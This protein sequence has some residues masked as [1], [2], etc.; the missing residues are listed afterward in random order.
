MNIVG[1]YGAFDWDAN[2]GKLTD[3]FSVD[4]IESTS[5]SHD[6]GCTLFMDGKHI[7]SVSEERITRTKYDG[8]YPKNSIDLCL[9]KGGIHR[10]DIDLVYFVPTHHFIAFHQIKSGLAN[11]ILKQSFPKAE[12]RFTGHHLAHAASTVFTSDFNEGT[13]V[14]FDGGGS[15]IQDP[16]RDYVDHIENNSIGYFNKKKRIFRFYNMFEHQ[17]NNFGQLYQ[18]VASKI[19]QKKTGEEIKHWEGITASN[20]KIMGL[21]AYG[22]PGD[23]PKGYEVT[24]HSI[25]YI[26][27]AAFA[28]KSDYFHEKLCD[29]MSPEDAAYYLQRTFE[30]GMLDLLKSLRK[31]HLDKNTCFAG[32]VFLNVLGNTLIKESGIFEDIHI[33]PFT[34]DSGVHFGA[35]IWG[36]YEN[37]EDISLPDNLALLGRDF[38]NDEIVQ[39]LDMFDLSYRDYDIDIVA[40]L[41]KDNKIVA[42][43]QGRSEAGPRALGSRSIFMSPTRAEN[44]DIL[45]KRV[46][47]RDHWRPFAGTI[48]EDRVGEYFLEAYTSPYMLYSQHSTTD[49]LPAI[50]HEDKTCRIQTVNYD[51]NPRVHDLLTRLD[52]PVILNTS[53][54]DNGEPIIDS[55]YD[56]VRAFTHLDID[57]MVIGDFIVD[58]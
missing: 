52:P 54:N 46:K 51:Q 40:D 45:N 19:Y 48:L 35:A 43:F 9:D 1:I 5:W 24:E 13:F 26:N 42:W 34:D 3:Y 14:T 20:G 37:E 29:M 58:K 2:H 38:H 6:S 23:H 18:S 21:S 10:R 22:T 4:S 27:F 56:A 28:E 31:G 49:E 30:D 57:H 41:I 25:P 47:H 39:Y 32:G 17:Y 8:N 55:P 11:K 44:K 36:C 53:F 7:C 50:T 12:I 16:T 15:A 33:P